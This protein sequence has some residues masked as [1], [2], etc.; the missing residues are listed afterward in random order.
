MHTVTSRDGTKIAFDKV[1]DGPALI[2]VDGALCSRSMGPNGRL[3]EEL[4]ERFTVFTYDRRGRGDSDDT[5]PYAVDREIEDV[6]ALIAE[7]GGS[8]SLY[9][10]SSGGVLALEAANR[11]TGVE[12]LFIYEVPFVVDDT[13]TPIP[14]DYAHHLDEL[15]AADRRGDAVK[16]F[17]RAAVQLPAIFVAMMRFM[18]AWKKLKAVAP[19]LRYDAAIIGPETGRGNPLPADR[20]TSVTARTVV[21][22]GSKSPAWMQNAQV[23]LAEV[24]GAEHRTLEG[25]NHMVKPKAL[26]P[27]ITEFLGG[28]R[29][30]EVAGRAA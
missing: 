28:D 21:V 5:A 10:I 14:P 8:A 19:T 18:P 25:Q 16:Y 24:L 4:R 11:L 3:A 13:R 17:M 1:G 30:V 23:A 26:A 22:G 20:W 7:A 9:G 15:I 29:D 6:E 27:M 2:L 12:K